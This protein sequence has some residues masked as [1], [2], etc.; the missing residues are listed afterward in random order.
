MK[1]KKA[2]CFMLLIRGCGK[3]LT[4]CRLADQA[5]GVR[6]LDP[7]VYLGAAN[8]LLLIVIG[9]A[10]AVTLAFDRDFV[11]A[12]P[13]KDRVGHSN[14]SV[15]FGSSPA[16]CAAVRR[17]T[18]RRAAAVAFA[19]SPVAVAGPVA[20]PRAACCLCHRALPPRQHGAGGAPH[21]LGVRPQ[22]TCWASGN[23][24]PA[25][26]AATSHP[27]GLTRAFGVAARRRTVFTGTTQWW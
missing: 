17:S 21:L 22:A 13:I 14:A 7:A 23:W 8:Q 18:A 12:N 15:G 9:I 27:G 10:W 1:F 11:A 26:R 5:G 25:G 24:P 20:G 6:F 19:R 2:T 4:C 16:R 3:V